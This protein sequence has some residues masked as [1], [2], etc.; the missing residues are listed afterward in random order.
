MT[1]LSASSQIG[2]YSNK[3]EIDPI[4]HYYPFYDGV[5]MIELDY[6]SAYYS[7]V[8]QLEQ[9]Q[10]RALPWSA[11]LGNP[12]ENVYLF[13]NQMGA[14]VNQYGKAQKPIELLSVKKSKKISI[15]HNHLHA[16]IGSSYGLSHI[17][18]RLYPYYLI[19]SKRDKDSQLGLIDSL[20]RIVLNPKHDDIFSNYEGSILIAKQG[21][22]YKLY[23]GHLELQYHTTQYVLSIAEDQQNVLF[24][25]DR[26]YGLK[27]AKGK[28]I[29]P[30]K[31]QI[32]W[33]YNNHGL[34]KVRNEKHLEGFVDS[35]GTEVIK[36]KYQNFG[37]FTEG[38][39]GARLNY[40]RGF[41]DTK[42][43]VVIPFIYDHAFWFSEGLARVSK[44]I[45]GIY[46]FGFIDKLGNEVIPLK[47]ANA[48][49]F[50][51][52]VAKVRIDFDNTLTK[53]KPAVTSKD[54]Y[55]K[56]DVT[57]EGTWIK[58]D[59]SGKEID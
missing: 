44:K 4:I 6:L 58:I 38:L 25:K 9:A 29:I 52:G 55:K 54:R 16:R 14:I 41:L 11:V 43:R 28:T 47:Y 51:D 30:C 7:T 15:P 3:H 45:D 20:G 49:D 27:N 26:R 5:Q 34:A 2:G 23:N 53:A 13:R 24:L 12:P 19:G 32:I 21:K 1:S 50:K 36:S 22:S 46:Y 37:K 31:Y 39:I 10:P 33:P 56:Q 35:S 17:R 59:L 48:T 42:G 40:K 57:S 8:N 18:T